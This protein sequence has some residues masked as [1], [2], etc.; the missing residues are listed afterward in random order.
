MRYEKLSSKFFVNNRSKY[1]DQLPEGSV[2][3]FGSNGFLPSNA[4]GTFGFIQNST[5]YYLTGIDQEDCFLVL[6][7]GGAE[8]LFTKE[9]SD[10]IKVWEGDKLG[11][12]EA[13]TVSGIKEVFWLEEFWPKLGELLSNKE[14]VFFHED[15]TVGKGGY[16]R[17]YESW[18]KA[19]FVDKF[20][21]IGIEN[22]ENIVSALRLFK[23]DEEIL[24]MRKAIDTTHKGLL[25]AARFLKPDCYE[26]EVEAEITHEFMMGRSRFHAFPPIVASGANAC[27]LHYV[28][29][30]AQC[31]DGDLLLIDFGAEYA[32]FKADMTRVL[33][34]NGKFTE[35]QSEVY[36]A[37]LDVLKEVKGLMQFGNDVLKL[38]TQTQKLVG[39]QLVKLKLVTRRELKSS[40]DI[41]LKYFPHGVSHSLG[42]DVHDVGDRGTPLAPGMVLTCE[43][44]I[45]IPEEKL[46]IRLENDILVTENG[47][48]D[49]MEGVPLEIDEIEAIMR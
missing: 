40:P 39:E 21:D 19:A 1:L 12:K 31:K 47:I 35:R 10:H 5:F 7:K 4:D 46:G 36:T 33:P 20:P 26:Y 23:E 42:I 11:K 6:E 14:K 13:F 27:V 17:S 16:F 43:P 22:P 37:V 49:L 2:S 32:N 3:I 48:V 28:D 24:A 9:T 34:V 41:V 25:R 18:T 8:W 44:G 29:N 38:R 45:Y 15:T 30:N